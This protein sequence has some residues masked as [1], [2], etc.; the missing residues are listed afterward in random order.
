MP[1]LPPRRRLR[2][3][4]AAAAAVVAAALG[5]H[6]AAAA[7]VKPADPGKPLDAV[8]DVIGM[9]APGTSSPPT[10][11]ASAYPCGA[12]A[13]ASMSQ[14]ST[15]AFSGATICLLNRER[16]RHGLR[17]LRLSRRLS[18]AARRHS[19]SMVARRFFAHGAFSARIRRTGY[20]RGARRWSVGENIAWGSGSYGSP[21]AIVR[22]WMNS[23]GH[24]R[25]ILG[26]FREVGIGV[27]PGAPLRGMGD[28]A[29]YT[30]DFGSRR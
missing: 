17:P 29:T 2:S 11:T 3:T 25:N 8:T 24:R 26:R 21:H 27:H 5:G 4:F 30:T 7:A 20:M 28:A 9:A 12:S 19:R 14:A 1:T 15:A 18:R 10:A 13:S 22:A 23:P 6:P 16:A